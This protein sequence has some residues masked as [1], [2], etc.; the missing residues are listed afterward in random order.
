MQQKSEI[1]EHWEAETCGTRDGQLSEIREAR[2]RYIPEI[3]AFADFKRAKGKRVLEIGVGAGTDFSHWVAA[4]AD[5]YG[6]DLTDAAIRTTREHLRAIGLSVPGDHLRR[7]DAESLDF[8][9][10]TFDLVWSWGVLHHS[11]DTA[12]A[13]GQVYRVLKPGGVV[14][15]MVYHSRSWTTLFYWTRF[16]LMRGKPMQSPRGIIATHMESPH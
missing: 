13:F 3:P 14:K 4:E 5:A 11:P 9:D 6:I 1:R 2:Y 7:G 16:A 10:E 8:A 12:A 15:A